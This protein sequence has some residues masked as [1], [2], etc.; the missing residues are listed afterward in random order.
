M[1]G[2]DGEKMS[3]SRATWSSSRRC[4]TAT[5]TRWRSGWRCCATTTARDW[6]WT[7]RTSSGTP[8]TTL[9]V[10]RRA[11]SLGAGAPAGT[12]RHR[13]VL[14]ALADD[15]DAPRAVA[16][17]DAW[18]DATLGTD[19]LADTSDP[20]AATTHARPV[21]DAAA[22]PRALGRWL[23]STA[24]PSVDV[25]GSVPVLVRRAA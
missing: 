9:A 15:L 18:V 17:V 7:R 11:L 21:L 2:Y 25:G 5:S 22:R 19:G 12:G 8:S 4:A 24:G 13:A 10:W 6:E 16:A 20:D 3:K 23:R 14:A 1:V